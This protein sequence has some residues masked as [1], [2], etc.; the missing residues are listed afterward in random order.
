M[1]TANSVE[2]GVRATPWLIRAA[3]AVAL[4]AVLPAA[5]AAEAANDGAEEAMAEIVVTGSRIVRR[6]YQSDSPIVTM[7]SDTLQATSEIGVEQ[8][9]NKMPQFTGGQNQFNNAGSITPTPRS[10]P[11]IATAN[12]RGLGDNRTLVLLDGRRSQPANAAMVVDLNTIPG[13]AVDNIE[14]ITGGAGSTYGADAVAGVVNFRLKR[15]FEGLTIEAQ[16]GMTERGDGEQTSIS[17]LLG[18]NFA[19]GRG[20]VMVGLNFARR[21]R[22][23]RE[24]VP[25]YERALTD[26]MSGATQFPNFAGFVGGLPGNIANAQAAGAPSQAALNAWLATMGLPAGDL[27]TPGST[28]PNAAGIPA[29]QAFAIYFN[30]AANWQDATLFMPGQGRIS[31]T[32]SPGYTGE[33]Y[34]GQK[35]VG[36]EGAQT[37]TTQDVGNSLQVPLTRYA[38]FMNSRLEVSDHVEAYVQARLDENSTFTR[39]S[40]VPAANQWGVTI[41]YGTGT[42]APSVGPDGNTLPAYLTGGAYGLNCPA[43]GGCTNSQAFPVPTVL[44]NLLDSRTLDAF[45]FPDPNAANA[46][47]NFNNNPDYMPRR[48]LENQQTTYELLAGIRGDLGVKDWT[49]DFFLSRGN[50]RV[51]TQYMGHFDELSYQTLIALPNY[52]QGQDFNNGRLGVLAHCTTGLNPFVTTPPSQDCLDIVDSH[53]KLTSTLQQEQAELN[54]QGGLFDLP[55]GNV[56]FAAGLDYRRDQYAYLPDQSMVTS[57]ITTVVAGQFDTT[58]TRGDV[59]VK[60]IYGELLVPVFKDLPLVQAFELNLGYRFSDYNIAAG[61]DSTW[62]ITAN[63]DVNDYIKLRGGR[64]VANRAPNIAELFSPAI[65]ETVGWA[66]HDPCSNLTRATYGNN[67]VN[68]DRAQ[69]NALCTQLPGIDGRPN[70]FTGFGD[71]YVGQNRTLFTAGRDLTVGNPNLESE[72]AKTWTFGAVL[73]SPFESDYLRNMTLSVDWYDIQIDDAISTASTAYV[74]QECFNFFGT[75]P[76]YDPANTFCQRIIRDGTNGNWLATTASFINLSTVSTSGVD[77]TFDYRIDTPFAGD[78]VGTLSLNVNANWLF[79]YEVQVAPGLPTF[80]YKDAVSSPYGSQFKYKLLT[81]IGYS[82]GPASVNLMWRHLPRIRNSAKVTN[83]NATQSDTKAY[84]YFGLSGR[85][86]INEIWSVRGGIDNLF[87]KEPP[88]TG[89]NLPAF[90]SGIGGTDSSSYDII[91]RRYYVGVTAKF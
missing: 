51:N 33:L 52:G 76:T 5:Q 10:S 41:P 31:G 60:E 19:D 70:G 84:D 54:I 75:N 32:L 16:T 53:A 67:P 78:R 73:R 29:A 46:N 82:V 42:Y 30:R 18:S 43:V 13:A 69:V 57:N 20:N 27:T 36:R 62:K 59:K 81:N 45:G 48:G 56:R 3:V 26:P 71:D 72:A 58:E 49:Y 7:S 25:F 15:N 89:E 14:V 79:G 86:S 65:F 11:G 55:A 22:V 9:L 38:L 83:P 91:G 66:D 6:D 17:T 90:T 39:S 2:S 63:W 37:L 87:D 23:I 61:S 88:I 35:Y 4:T 8:S 24:D 85:W 50:T 40:P 12:L 77:A 21:E 47:W 1:S 64:Q 68:P 34:P 28:L 44:A 74:Y 80:D